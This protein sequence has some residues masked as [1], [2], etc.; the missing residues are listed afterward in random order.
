[1][2]D[3]I[4]RR[5]SATPTLEPAAQVQDR[6]HRAP[7]PR[8]R[9]RD[10]RRLPRRRRAPR[11]RPRLRPLGRRRPLDR[12]RGWPSA[13]ASSCA[14]AGG[15]R[16]ARRRSI[17]RDYGYRRLRNKARLKFL[18]AEWGTAK[19]REVLET[20]Y[21]GYALPDGPAPAPRAR[22]RATTSACT[23]RRTAT[24]T[25]A[26][27]PTVGRISG[28]LLT[29]L[30]DLIESYGADRRALTAHQKL[31]ILDVPEDRVDAS[32][33]AARGAR[34]LRPGPAPSAARRWRAPASSSASSRSSRRRPTRPTPSPSSRQRLADVD[35][36]A[37]ILLN[38]NGC[39]N[40][41]A[42]IQTADIGLK[43]QLV[44]V[45]G[46]QE[47]GFQVHLGGGLA[48]ADRDE[49]GLGRTVRGLKVTA[50]GAARL[51][52]ARRAL[53][54]RPGAPTGETFA[55]WSH[56]AEEGALQ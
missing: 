21:L 23:G 6:D 24:S 9:P 30:G 35:L 1:M 18:L 54:R 22:A 50:D 2:I 48:S 5:S 39:P 56:R 27:R 51:R 20:E 10:Q 42:R 7:E 25:S 8:R 11:A 26:R 40:S 53:L 31:V 12:A 43:G 13:S 44:T 14:G 32:H 41:C 55:E 36:A 52:R 16:L 3:A 15:R 4:T 37:P 49:A 28:T 34:P 38:V 47:P 19:F 33:R 17:F 29:R 45:D 46:E